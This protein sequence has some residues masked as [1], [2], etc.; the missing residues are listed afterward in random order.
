MR[1]L[2]DNF[3]QAKMDFTNDSTISR[4]KL[5]VP[6]D[7]LTIRD[8]PIERGSV[9]LARYKSHACGYAKVDIQLGKI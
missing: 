2:M 9:S 1:I 8:Q 3:D 4:V 5:P 7:E 6:L